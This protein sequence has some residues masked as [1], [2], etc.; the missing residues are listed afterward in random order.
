M[1]IKNQP[2]SPPPPVIVLDQETLASSST[3]PSS[4][5]FMFFMDPSYLME[6][7]FNPM[8]SLPVDNTLA[9]NPSLVFA[10][11]DTCPDSPISLVLP[12]IPRSYYGTIIPDTQFSPFDDDSSPDLG[13]SGPDLDYVE[14]EVPETQL[15]SSDDEIMAEL[16][17]KCG[18]NDTKKVPI[19]SIEAEAHAYISTLRMM[20]CLLP[21][22]FGKDDIDNKFYPASDEIKEFLASPVNQVVYSTFCSFPWIYVTKNM[23]LHGKIC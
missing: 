22:F 21:R 3:L 8:V 16:E 20:A 10:E 11:S 5:S 7:N 18:W 12:S 15:S 1:F 17:L 6:S 14:T 23:K 4:N 9:M 19:V 2:P 13:F